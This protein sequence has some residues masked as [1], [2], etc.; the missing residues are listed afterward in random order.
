MDFML[1]KFFHW[2]VRIGWAGIKACQSYHEGELN[3]Y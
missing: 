3:G 2:C 1:L